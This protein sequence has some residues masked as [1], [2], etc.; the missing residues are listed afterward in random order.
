M[1]DAEMVNLK[2]AQIIEVGNRFRFE[3]C[4]AA[5]SPVPNVVI[6][7]SREPQP[8][9]KKFDTEDGSQI[10]MWRTSMCIEHKRTGA[11]IHILDANHPELIPGEYTHKETFGSKFAKGNR[12][13]L[14]KELRTRMLAHIDELIRAELQVIH[15]EE[16]SPTPARTIPRF[17]GEII[18]RD[19]VATKYTCA[20]TMDEIT[21]DMKTLVT[22]CFHIFDELALLRWLQSTNVCPVCKASV[23]PAEC[24]RI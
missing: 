1:F 2:I 11:W 18:K 17:V 4:D 23:S 13:I 22:P 7:T 19:A 24:L 5:I 15:R 16:N 21:E 20:I 6:R 8:T 3:E 12:N 9:L 14:Y 10:Y